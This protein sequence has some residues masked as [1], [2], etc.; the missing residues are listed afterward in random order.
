MYTCV[1]VY[2]YV[3]VYNVLVFVSIS[4]LVRMCSILN[5]WQLKRIYA[6]VTRTREPLCE[7]YVCI[8]VCILHSVYVCVS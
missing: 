7:Y 5:G 6:Y 3:Q 2:Q 1:C 4:Q 8:Y